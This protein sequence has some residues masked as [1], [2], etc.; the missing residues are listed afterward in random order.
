MLLGKKTKKTKKGGFL[1][2]MFPY[3]LASQFGLATALLP[4]AGTL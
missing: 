1:E 3:I 2:G 4:A